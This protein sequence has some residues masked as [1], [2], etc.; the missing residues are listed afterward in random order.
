MAVADK[1][2]DGSKIN[3]L[4]GDK[5]T[6][7][8]DRD[9]APKLLNAPLNLKGV[10]RELDDIL[11]ENVFGIKQTDDYEL[12]INN[13]DEIEPSFAYVWEKAHGFLH[14]LDDGESALLLGE[15]KE[16]V[17]YINIL[18]GFTTINNEQ[19]DTYKKYILDRVYSIFQSQ[20]SYQC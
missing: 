12:T 4:N 19:K 1:M 8:L 18:F 17:K 5:S 7:K 9:P 13:A 2:V 3:T 16:G 6:I 20:I 10:F 14:K 15:V 11:Y